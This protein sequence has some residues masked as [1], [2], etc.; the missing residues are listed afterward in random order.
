V[1]GQTASGRAE[2]QS[3]AGGTALNMWVRDLP[4]DPSVVYEV[5]C[6]APDWSAS[7]GTFRVDA[8]GRAHVVLTT[9]ARRSEYDS[10]RV[11]RR[12]GTGTTDV[13]SAQ[14]N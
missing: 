7:A 14:L 13:M 5:R 1:G 6:D 8:R 11:V 10:I 3:V 2:L 4:A 9:A 12:S